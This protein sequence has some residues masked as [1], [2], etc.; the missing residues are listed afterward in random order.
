MDGEALVQLALLH[1]R[2]ASG[3]LLRI[4]GF[5][6]QLLCAGLHVLHEL[7]LG[8]CKP[9]DFSHSS[10]WL[11][12]SVPT[13]LGNNAS[14]GT[15]FQFTPAGLYSTSRRVRRLFIRSRAWTTSALSR[16]AMSRCT[17]WVASRGPWRVVFSEDAP[18]ILESSQYSLL[19]RVVH[20]TRLL[21]ADSIRMRSDRSYRV[22]G[23]H[24]PSV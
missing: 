10:I 4:V 24:P 7:Y 9:G 17:V 23:A 2:R 19:I 21:S 5:G 12:V 13:S 16:T 11:A 18:G 20:G 15:K 22:G 8:G 14:W 1:S 6:A 3:D